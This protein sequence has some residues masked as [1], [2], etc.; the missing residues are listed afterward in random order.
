MRLL[1]CGSRNWDDESTAWTAIRDLVPDVVIHGAAKGADA[2][3]DRWAQC[4]GIPCASF[5]A[6]WSQGPSAGPKRN[7]RMLAEG[8]P[9]RGLAFGPVWKMV[10]TRRQGRP[11][12]W[13][14]TG[15][16]D[17]VLKMLRA[18]LP[19]RWVEKPGA[20]PVDLTE[21]PKPPE[22]T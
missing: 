2:I 20:D 8:K 18:G 15:T 13:R 6:E 5:P 14:T 16:G 21:T 3:A 10:E 12:E 17:M 22:R 4:Y 11:R 1:V 19:V 9:D 7:A